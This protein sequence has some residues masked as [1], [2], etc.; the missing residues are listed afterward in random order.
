[1]KECEF[2]GVATTFFCLLR[3]LSLVTTV[4]ISVFF[5]TI[6][7]RRVSGLVAILAGA[8]VSF[9]G[10]TSDDLEVSQLT[11]RCSGDELLVEEPDDVIVGGGGAC[12]F[13]GFLRPIAFDAAKEVDATF[14]V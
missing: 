11:S 3:G 10:F 4:C 1:M 2:F 14:F 7:A 6:T 8:F 5:S 13:T 9:T 12:F